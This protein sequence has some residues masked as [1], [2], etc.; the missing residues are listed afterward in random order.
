MEIYNGSYCVYVHINQ[1]NGKMYVGQTCQKPEKRWKYGYGY[2]KNP[3][4][5]KAIEKY[6]WDNFEHEVIA[7]NLTKEEADNFEKVLIN[8]LN[9]LNPDYGYNLSEGG[10]HGCLS[11]DTKQKMREARSGEKH[12]MYGKHLSEATKQKISESKQ[13]EKNNFYGKHHTEETKK[14]I[15]Q[16]RYGSKN[17][18]SIKVYQY[19]INGNFIAE[20]DNMTRVAEAYNVGRSTVMRYCRNQKIF[21]HKFILKLEKT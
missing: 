6:G 10:S 19:D 5:Y 7:S 12:Y 1:I 8:K 16:A 14:K 11:E 13:G 2:I 18:N 4:F 17:C 3:Y 20:W 9:L 21:L 15:G